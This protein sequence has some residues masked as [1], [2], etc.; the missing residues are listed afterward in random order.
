MDLQKNLQKYA[1]LIVRA[2]CNLQPGQELF[3]TAPI[4]SAPLTRLVA[5]EAYAAGVREV[6]VQWTD[7][8]ISRMAYAHAPMEVFTH[9][10]EW[11]ATLTNGV[12]ERGAAILSILSSAPDAMRG[13]D[14]KRIAARA[15]A[16]HEACKAFHDGMDF[17]RNVWCIVGASA[18]EWAVHVFPSLPSAE[19]EEKLWE[20]IFH[21]VRLDA[22]DPVAAWEAHRRSFDERRAWLN[23]RQFDRLHYRNNGGT[24]IVLGLPANHVW[25]GGGSQTVN[26]TFFFPN[27]PTEEIFC[28]PDCRRTEGTVHSSL[29]LNYNGSLVENFSIT[30]HAGRVAEFHAARG[31]DALREILATDEGAH[32]LGECALVPQHSPIAEMG[33]LFYNTLYDENASC[34]FALGLGFP[35][36]I[37]GGLEMDAKALQAAG[38]NISATH[39]DFMLG[40]PDLEI[41]G[42]TTS[43]EE[44]PIFQNGNWAF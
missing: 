20:A 7:E 3:I 18:P 27:M 17:G 9:C 11:L 23:E 2:G 4:E 34:H 29:P 1:H 40:T 39:V 31:E 33:L 28:S 13:I 35:E 32:M 36:C 44:T 38:V 42:I 26:G 22:E 25:Q 14:P 30:F 16:N 19:A 5:E 6:T 43:G 12:A 21:T 37:K 8:A 41:T 24:D 10:P 15:K